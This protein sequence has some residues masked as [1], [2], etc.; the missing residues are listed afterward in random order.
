MTSPINGEDQLRN[1]QKLEAVGTLAG[2]VAHDFN[3]LLVGI[4]G[5]SQLIQRRCEPGSAIAASAEVIDQAAARAAELTGQLLAFARRGKRRE[6]PVDVHQIVAEVVA[7]VGPTVARRITIDQRLEAHTHVCLGDPGQLQQVVMNLAINACDAMPDG[8]SLTF[9]TGVTAQPPKAPTMGPEVGPG[10]HLVL[11]VTD[12]GAGIAEEARPHIFEPFFTT[13]PVGQG[14]GMGLSTVYGIVGSHKGWLDLDV[15]T[16]GRTTFHVGLPL[17]DQPAEPATGSEG[18]ELA[19]GLGHILVVDDEAAVRGT[20]AAMLVALGYESTAVGSGAE[21]IEAYGASGTAFDLVI[22]DLT[23]PVMDGMECLQALKGIDPSVPVVVSTGK[24]V[25]P[26]SEEWT[27][28]G[29]RGLVPKPFR[30]AEL[31]RVVAAA[32]ARYYELRFYFC[33]R[34]RFCFRFC[35]CFCF[36][37]KASFR[38][39]VSSR[40]GPTETMVSGT[41]SCFSMNRRYLRA[42]LGSCFS[43][44]QPV[45]SSSQPGKVS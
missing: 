45:M 38:T 27:A 29:L 37:P 17:A 41:A 32:M 18:E 33:F 13:K 3:N 25:D 28:L 30:M 26:D 43:F 20:L 31:S 16:A 15:G 19:E 22:L 7:I 35:F 5:H 2:G 24:A 4:L 1:V 14:T 36:S 9:T 11:S 40:R 12:T 42:A 23:M 44:R 8:G 21:A 10:P 39:I 34:F 6:V